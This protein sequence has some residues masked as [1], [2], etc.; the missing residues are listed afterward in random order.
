M[1]KRERHVKL[2]GTILCEVFA[3]LTIIYL[4]A[5]GEADRL[6]LAFGTLLLALLPMLLEKLFQCRIC[7]PAYLFALAYA[8]GPMLG[9]C[10]KLYYTVPVWDKLLHT[11]GGVMFA[12]LGA[13]IFDLLAKNKEL[14]AARVIFALCFS[15]AIAVLWEFCEFGGDTF[16]GMDT[17][18]DTVIHGLTSY[19]LGD[20]LGMTGSILNIQSVSVNGMLLPVDGYIDIGLIDTMLDMLLETMGA[21]AACVIIL[22]DKDRHPII[23][24]YKTL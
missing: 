23:Q 8:I 24:D 14:P 19:L 1:H 16:L 9:H 13:Y 3:I 4:L 6:A 10:W 18:A 20:S 7:L 12:I 11:S 21:I 15:M 17:Q 22:L 2:F 5:D